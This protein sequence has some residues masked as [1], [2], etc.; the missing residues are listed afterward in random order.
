MCW[1]NQQTL[2][3]LIF[4]EELA[5]IAPKERKFLPDLDNI[6]VEILFL[7]SLALISNIGL[8]TEEAITGEPNYKE[9]TFNEET[10][11]NN[12]EITALG[13]IPPPDGAGDFNDIG[14]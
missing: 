8:L 7:L 12:D 13:F 6:G 5:A 2:P 4:G 3:H 10:S 1:N 9:P 14:G 11:P